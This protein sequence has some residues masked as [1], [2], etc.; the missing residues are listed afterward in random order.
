MLLAMEEKEPHPVLMELQ[1]G[2]AS[3]IGFDY[4]QHSFTVSAITEAPKYL[5]RCFEN[6]FLQK[7][8]IGVYS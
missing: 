2:A 1:L 8:F 7:L 6:I 4:S 5:P 3:L